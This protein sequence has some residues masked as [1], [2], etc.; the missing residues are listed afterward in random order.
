MNKYKKGSMCEKCGERGAESNYVYMYGIEHIRRRCPNC[1]Y[2]WN[3][4][5]LSTFKEKNNESR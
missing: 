4:K 2:G 1:C 3:E 5:P